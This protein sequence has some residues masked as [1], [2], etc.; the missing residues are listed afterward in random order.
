MCSYA[1]NRPFPTLSNAL[2]D[3]IPG[4]W[5][6]R[7]EKDALLFATAGEGCSLPPGGL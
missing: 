1:W 7:V 3:E 2:L 6:G 5:P 4:D